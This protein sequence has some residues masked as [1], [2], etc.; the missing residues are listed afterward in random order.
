MDEAAQ[1]QVSESGLS[2]R[3]RLLNAAINVFA[4]HGYHQATIREICDRA[5]ANVA[6]VNYHFNSKDELY[7]QAVHQIYSQ[8]DLPQHHDPAGKGP[9]RERLRSFIRDH[10]RG[11]SDQGGGV[12]LFARILSWE[13]MEPSPVFD[14]LFND[15]MKPRAQAL[16]AILLDL[17]GKPIDPFKLRACAFSILGQCIIYHKGEKAIRKLDPAFMERPGLEEEVVEHIALFSEAG[18]K[19]IVAQEQ[20]ST[21]DQA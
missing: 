21:G 3:Q 9:P 16:A 7:A 10:L 13:L 1:T 6:A 4:E 5:D 15:C 11:I 2:T 19:A 17:A 20:E 18:L 14:T 12:V 8:T